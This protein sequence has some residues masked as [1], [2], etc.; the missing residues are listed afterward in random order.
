MQNCINPRLYLL[1]FIVMMI[2][3][4]CYQKVEGCLDI[5]ATNFSFVA[6]EQC[7]DCCTYPSLKLSVKHNWGNTLLLSDSLY[8]NAN[9]QY[10]KILS[11]KFYLSDIALLN[12]VDAVTVTEDLTVVG[13]NGIETEIDDNIVFV[14]N[15]R[16][17]YTVGTFQDAM[18]Y[19][20]LRFNLGINGNYITS[21]SLESF[22]EEDDFFDEGNY[23]H[24]NFKLEYV[25][26]T[27]T[28]DTLTL[29]FQDITT[30][31]NVSLKGEITMPVGENY[32]V[33]IIIDYRLLLND[34]DFTFLDQESQRIT[35]LENMKSSFSLE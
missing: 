6:D 28:M 20:G 26:D 24:T 3:S 27:M 25:I 10:I 11:S 5:G 7:D 18:S 13:L 32:T 17:T 19:N 23:I 30:V 31:Q 9:S 1:A 16:F 29:A 8:Q 22:V 34:I 33:P 21:D 35:I 12:D 14:Q 4:S 2:F 15:S